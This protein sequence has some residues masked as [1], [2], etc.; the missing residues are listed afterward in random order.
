VLL[1]PVEYAGSAHVTW[2]ATARGMNT[3]ARG[4][5]W[6]SGDADRST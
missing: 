5:F 3:I 6:V 2:E 1:V 4:E